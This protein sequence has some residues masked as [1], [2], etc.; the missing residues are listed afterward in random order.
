MKKLEKELILTPAAKGYNILING[1]MRFFGISFTLPEVNDRF[2]AWKRGG[3]LVFAK[4]AVP[5]SLS[6]VMRLK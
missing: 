5:K 3:T 1:Q 4:K 6:E 2:T